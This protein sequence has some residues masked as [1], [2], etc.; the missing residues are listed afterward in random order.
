M[1]KI[2]TILTD[3]F[4]D[5]E[6]SLL[7]AVARGFYG[8][9]T[10]YATLDGMP[11]VTSAVT[12]VVAT[13]PTSIPAYPT[14]AQGMT[15]ATPATMPETPAPELGSALGDTSALPAGAEGNFGAVQFSN[16]GAASAQAD[17]LAGL[18][19]LHDFEYPA[20]AEAFRPWRAAASRRSARRRLRGSPSSRLDRC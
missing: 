5:W 10:A 18:A 1:T 8:V 7:N 9:D 15:T 19:L 3:G 2:V 17:F 4:A 14:A 13:V 6:T 16:S 11:V 20:A 12:P